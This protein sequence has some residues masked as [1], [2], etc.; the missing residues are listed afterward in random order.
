MGYYKFLNIEQKGNRA[1]NFK[2][3]ISF[4]IRVAFSSP[5]HEKIA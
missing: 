3:I 5:M 4:S 1:N 2:P